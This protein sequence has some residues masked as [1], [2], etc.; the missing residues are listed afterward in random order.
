MKLNTY[1][2]TLLLMSFFMT[3]NTSDKKRD[4][5]TTIEEMK[6][7][8]EEVVSE[9]DWAQ[10]HSAKNLSM[11]LAA[12]AAE[13][14][15]IFMWCDNKESSAVLEKKRTEVEH[16]LADI[17][18]YALSFANRCDIDLASAL[19]QKMELNKKKYP[20]DKARGKS[21]KYTAYQ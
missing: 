16:E 8:V 11:A 13:L 3:T 19:L 17:L 20:V 12:E 14:M 4:Q 2:W 15:E 1:Y 7:I 9:R 10:F 21:D 5:T 6:K 18:I